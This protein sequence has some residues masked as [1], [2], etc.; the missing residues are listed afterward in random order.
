MTMERRNILKL[1]GVAGSGAAVV[2]GTGAFSSVSA[3]RAVNVEVSGDASA[4]LA[5]DGT[6]NHDDYIHDSD[7]EFAIDLTQSDEGATGVNASASTVIDDLFEVTNKGTQEVELDL[8]PMTFVD[9]DGSDELSVLVVPKTNFPTVTLGVGESETYGLVID[10]FSPNS[11][12]L[13]VDSTI[14]F[15]AE[16]TN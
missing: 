3:E 2:T 5:I 7:G 10:E 8:S 12:G 14:E 9:G 13:N 11:S 15:T 1:L 6:G 4:L 16:A